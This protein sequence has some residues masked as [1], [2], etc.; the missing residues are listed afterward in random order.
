MKKQSSPLPTIRDCAFRPTCKK[1]NVALM[2]GE[3]IKQTYVSSPDDLG[4]D[5]RTF[6]A[7]GSGVLV[8]C[9]KCPKCGYSISR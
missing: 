8:P 7:G 6:Y 4:G 2:Q 9:W 5:V 1:C 3:A